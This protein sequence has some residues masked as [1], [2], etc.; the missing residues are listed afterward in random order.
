MDGATYGGPKFVSGIAPAK[1]EQQEKAKKGEASLP[2]RV[3][4]YGLRR[5]R[6]FVGATK[7]IA[8]VTQNEATEQVSPTA[9]PQ[10][11]NRILIAAL[12]GICFLTLFPFRILPH[13]K[14]PF[15]FLLGKTLGKTPGAVGD[16]FLNVLLFVPLGFGLAEKLWERR[17]SRATIFFVVWIT[18]FVLSYLVEFTQLYIPGRDSGWEDVITNSTGAVLGCL[19]FFAAGAA[20]LRFLTRVETAIESQVTLARL[21]VILVVYFACWFA[22]SAGLQTKTRLTN[23]RPDS[24]LLVGSDAVGK[25][26][27]LWQGK[28]T[29]LEVWDQPLSREAAVA[30]TGGTD[31]KESAPGAIVAYD[32]A[33]GPPFS[34]RMK[35]LP[36]LSWTFGVEGHGDPS[37]LAPD[38]GKSM[39][40]TAPAES[41]IADLERT[42]R[43]AIHLVCEAT[44]QEGT[45]AQVVS[46]SGPPTVANMMLRQ[47]GSSLEFWFRSPLSARHANLAWFVPNIFKPNEVRNILYSY[48]GS[49]LSLYV[50]GKLAAAPYRLGPGAAAAHLIHRIRPSELDGYEDIYYG[51]VFVPAGI[52]LG[53]SA[54]AGRR[55][56]VAAWLFIAMVLTVPPVLFEWLLIAVS[57]QAVSAGNVVLWAALLGGGALWINA[58]GRS[59]TH[60]QGE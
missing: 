58:D 23:W 2:N 59:K 48:D 13:A 53:I 27:S 51:F 40:L 28:V 30:L 60:P 12:V 15:V 22:L 39:T 44:A 4:K 54:R 50:D 7:E 25:P 11:S 16:D 20:L 34:D 31:P 43:F 56:G 37:Q 10:W 47:Q 46:I 57:G 26:G 17:K 42:N 19:L 24:R 29:K 36:D 49:N 1:I 14:Q 3:R 33:A 18:G 41:L 8:Y 6:L 52:A 5:A 55:R 32:F 38:N 21:G 45:Y 9:F 35:S